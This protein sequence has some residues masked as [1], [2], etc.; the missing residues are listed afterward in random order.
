MPTTSLTVAVASSEDDAEQ[1]AAGAVNLTSTDL[2]FVNDDASGAGDQLVGMR[3]NDISIP[4]GAVVTNATIQFT[5]DESQS[6]ITTLDIFVEA[7]NNAAAFADSANNLGARTRVSLSVPWAPAAW[8]AGQSN[9]TQRTPN[10]AGLVQEVISRPGWVAGNPIVFLA[11][12]CLLSGRIAC[13][14]QVPRIAIAPWSAPS[15]L[16]KTVAT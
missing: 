9:V 4:P 11:E 3:F 1:S 15:G 8:T 12:S 14:S 16:I 2:E 7:A 10:L 5:A 6:D 13:L